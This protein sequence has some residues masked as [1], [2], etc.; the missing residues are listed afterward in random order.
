MILISYLETAIYSIS[1]P[2]YHARQ[3]KRQNAMLMIRYLSC[4]ND[5]TANSAFCRYY[6]LSIIISSGG[7]ADALP[8]F[9]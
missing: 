1:F 3:K 4:F 5:I 2:K 9:S 6:K 7:G 8:A